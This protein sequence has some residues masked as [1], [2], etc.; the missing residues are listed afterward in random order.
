MEWLTVLLVCLFLFWRRHP[1]THNVVQQMQKD[2]VGRLVV[3]PLYP[4]YSIS[5]TG[6]SLRELAKH[7]PPQLA[8]NTTVIPFWYDRPGYVAAVSTLISHEI[9]KF[10]PEQRS[11]GIHVLFSAHGV[12][13][14]RIVCSIA[15]AA[16]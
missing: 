7:L 16:V 2:G 4:H 10:S 6:S 13:K 11:K 3:L 14:V 15:V 5:T 9:A 12:P 8:E 1:L